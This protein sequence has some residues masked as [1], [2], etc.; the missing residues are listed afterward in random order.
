MIADI[1][2]Q[3]GTPFC[4]PNTFLCRPSFPSIQFPLP[5]IFAILP[6]MTDTELCNFILKRLFALQDEKYRAFNSSLI[7]NIDAGTM[8]GVRVPALRTLAK[9]L[10]T[11]IE[12]RKYFRLL[13]HQYFEENML[14]AFMICFIKD[15]DECAAAAE[16]FLPYIDNWAV[17]D[18]FSPQVFKKQ[19]EKLLPHIERWLNSEKPYTVRFAIGMLMQHFLDEH[20]APEYL[21]KV[22]AVSSSEYYVN[23]MR[24]WY[25]ATALAKQY[26]RAVIY[27]EENRLDAWTH[28]M[29]I[30]KANE[31]R[32][33]S[34]ET[35][36]YLS[37]FRKKT[38]AKN[39]TH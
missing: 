30:R 34:A 10:F 29:T 13:P 7:P 2:M 25:F 3:V 26:E 19:P 28:N 24:A 36:R 23:M 38:T 8:I 32:R 17:C 37:T 20:F 4:F 15:F 11:T 22:A 31:S 33:I 39:E 27:I 1:L 5:G 21:K 14:H 9:E 12:Y 16:D 35:K 18:T 6:P